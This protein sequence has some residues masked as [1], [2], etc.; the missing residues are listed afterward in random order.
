M[1]GA[2]AF[3]LGDAGLERGDF[4]VGPLMDPVPRTQLFKVR[5]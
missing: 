5:D 3:E 1:G 2:F 4:L